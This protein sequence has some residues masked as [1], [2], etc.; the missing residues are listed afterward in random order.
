MLILFMLPIF[1]IGMLGGLW[2]GLLATLTTA[3]LTAFF[4]VPPIGS[5]AIATSHDAYQ[6]GVLILNGVLVSVFSEGLHRARWRETR[7]WQ[8]LEAAQAEIRQTQQ[9][10][11]RENA[12]NQAL[13]LNA[14]DGVGILAEDG[15]IL[16]ASNTLC[17][18]LGYSR[19]ELLGMNVSQVDAHLGPAELASFMQRQFKQSARSQFETRLKR[20]DGGTIE[21]EVS[22]L[23]IELDGQ[24]VLFNSVRDIT[25]R[26][27]YEE[28]LTLRGVALD[29]AANAI[30][31]TDLEGRLEWAN[32][33][34]T[35]LT[36]YALEEALGRKVKDLV[37]SGKQDKA[38][39]KQLWD[40][41]L[42]GQVWEGGLIN[43]RKDGSFY[44]EYQTITPVPGEDGG[45]HHFV[46]IKQDVT[47]RMWAEAALRES[48][49]TYRSLFENMLNGFAYCEMVFEDGEPVDLIYLS[50]NHAFETLTGLKDVVGKKI[51]EVIPSIRDNDPEL[52]QIYGRVATT[53]NPE[54]FETFVIALQMWFDVAVY[55]P[56]AGYFVVVFDVISERKQAEAALRES[57]ERYRLLVEQSVDGILVHDAERR[58]VDANP[59]ACRIL[60]YSR[61]EI[62]GLTVEDM[63]AE[64]EV[65]RVAPD[66]ARFA[67]GQILPSEYRCKRKDGAAFIGEVTGGPLSNGLFLGILRDIT[68]RRR[69]QEELERYR[70]HLEQLVAERTAQMEIERD[71]AETA[72]RAKSIFLANMSH[73]IRT[74]LNAILG[75]TH[76]LRHGIVTPSQLESLGKIDTAGRHLLSIINDILDLSKID[77]GRLELEC[78]DF[79]LPAVFDQIRSLIAEQARSKRL[80]L[81][82]QTA[83]LPPWLKGDPT[84]L[85]QALLNYL[86]NA[87]KFT[88]RGSVSLCVKVL[89]EEGGTLWLRFEVS[90]T[91]IGVDPE[92]ISK[93]FKAF[94]QADV[95]T[96]RRHGG[97][98]LGLAITCKLVQLM[99]GE[100]GMDSV[101]GQGST[102]WFTAKLERGQQR[103]PQETGVSLAQAEAELR[104]KHAGARLLLVEDNPINQDVAMQMLQAVGLTVDVADNGKQAVE[105]ARAFA[106]DLILMDMQM[107]EMSGLEATQVIRRLP[108]R[109]TVPILAMTANAFDEDRRDCLAA[110][111]NDFVAKPVDPEILYAILL[112]WLPPGTGKPAQTTPEKPATDFAEWMA[113]LASIPGFDVGLG[114]KSVRGNTKTYLRMLGLMVQEHA[115]DAGR[116]SEY[117]ACG[118]WQDIDRLAHTLKGSAGSIGAKQVQALAEALH[119]AIQHGA[120]ED[121]IR[122]HG[123]ALANE[124]AA[125]VEALQ[126]MKTG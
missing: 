7:H 126:A 40:T 109:E 51:T 75:L 3:T 73:E 50:V 24:K 72:N 2:P 63:I 113:Q 98:G 16:E 91:G 56:K 85:R 18:M 20:K 19:E 121:E 114:L 82:I 54:R 48:E 9:A 61:E 42:S 79:S 28:A 21:G 55:S 11:L 101:P 118:Q 52:L 125:L 115:A 110:G 94:E 99:G 14:S 64:G 34:F 83:G 25:E 35:V 107:P 22:G 68:E 102:F 44:H 78:I 1:L 31:I 119:L 60:G 106:Y 59:A 23:P 111:M 13:L 66:E 69:A 76:L 92:K 77:A 26:K 93:L 38:F 84:R 39:F 108:G 5:F 62:L 96:T 37:S 47:E 6:W 10:L 87:V 81:D 45:I 112:K 71:R 95:S 41:I 57:E 90:D 33:A 15:R 65:P 36:G 74:P 4:L 89:S 97:T 124:L 53:G 88:E 86:G 30:V 103:L 104:G 49:K 27:R 8:E 70:Q 29:A 12:K 117:L 17:A 43:R 100:V 105:R 46:A 120:G 116:L 58:Y 32:R 67:A 80:A 123:K 122:R